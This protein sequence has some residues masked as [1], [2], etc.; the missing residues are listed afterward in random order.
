MHESIAVAAAAIMLTTTGFGVFA[1][2]PPPAEPPPAEP[3]PAEPPAEPP[4]A[5]LPPAEPPAEPPPPVVPHP[6]YQPP[7]P[8]YGPPPTPGYGPGPY[9]YGPGHPGLAPQP[10]PKPPS[11]GCCLWSLRYDPFDLLFRRLTFEGEIALGSLPLSITI[12]PSWIFDAPSEDMEESGFD[13]AA[14]FAWYISGDALR[15]FWLKAHAEFEIFQ[16][17]LSREVDGNLVGKPDPSECDEDSSTGQCTKGINSF[18]VG[19]MVGST[20]VFGRRGGFAISGGIGIGVALA[21]KASLAVM[22]CTEADVTAK[23]PHCPKAEAEGA[24]GLAQSYYDEAARIR[25]IGSLGL[26]VAF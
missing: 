1:Q 23:D 12:S 21:E 22:P 19:L 10:P 6:L 5:V 2:T 3:P 16:A 11:R 7:Q 18:I 26:G 15:G 8:Y 9:G 14:D 25:L 17:T 13:I 24:S 20:H 4:P